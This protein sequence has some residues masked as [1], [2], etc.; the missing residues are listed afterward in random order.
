MVEEERRGMRG[1]PEG[2]KKQQLDKLADLDTRRRRA[3]NLA[4][5]GLLSPDELRAKLVALEEAL[6]NALRELAALER[7][8]ERVVGLERDRDVFLEI[9]TRAMPEAL[10]NLSPEQ[11]HHI[12]KL[13]GLVVMVSRDDALE[14][15]GVLNP[16]NL[17]GFDHT[18]TL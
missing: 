12:Y 15:S 9:Y 3:Q 13:L 11:R 6:G 10:D 8:G 1:D 2:D 14:V 4:V 7:R 5:E 16:Q 17:D 18:Q